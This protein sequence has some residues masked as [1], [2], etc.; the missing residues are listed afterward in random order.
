MLVSLK[1]VH[2]SILQ[3]RYANYKTPT[4]AFAD[5]RR[6]DYER[7]TPKLTEQA[8]TKIYELEYK[9]F[10]LALHK[11]QIGDW[12]HDTANVKYL[13]WKTELERLL[14]TSI[15]YLY[16]TF[17]AWAT[18]EEHLFIIGEK[19]PGGED[20]WGYEI[21]SKVKT[22]HPDVEEGSNE[23]DDIYE[24]IEADKKDEFFEEVWN[25]VE[26]YLVIQKAI[27]ALK[28][29][30]GSVQDRIVMFHKGLTTAHN[31]GKMLEY[32]IKGGDQY[33]NKIFLDNLSN[34]KLIPKWNEEL[35]RVGL[36]TNG[37]QLTEVIEKHPTPE[38]LVKTLL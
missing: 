26:P 22:L 20:D 17:I 18:L 10:R 13:Q 19:Y 25:S 29:P 28:N 8:I 15:E 7:D 30:T 2:N 1:E 9:L 31:N 3:E 37:L 6:A 38:E 14:T 4:E 33:N 23:Y 11:K 21:R 5:R 24:E 32:A 12:L 27:D 35:K 34:G 36:V 16:D